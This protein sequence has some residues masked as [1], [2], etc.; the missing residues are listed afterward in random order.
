MEVKNLFE[1][2]PLYVEIQNIEVRN[3]FPFYQGNYTITPKTERQVLM[4]EETTMR[5]NLAIEAI[6]YQEI[7]NE[8]GGTTVII[9]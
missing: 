4:T 1:T 6:P 9:G 8:A 7:E 3:G 5:E 2:A